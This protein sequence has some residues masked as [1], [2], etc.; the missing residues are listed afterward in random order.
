MN[1]FNSNVN[2]YSTL[3]TICYREMVYLSVIIAAVLVCNHVV[4]DPEILLLL[5]FGFQE[6]VESEEA[7]FLA[8]RIPLF[9]DL[10]RVEI[11]NCP[12][13]LQSCCC[14]VTSCDF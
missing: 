12:V 10:F 3:E 6:A 14:C 7:P 1:T 8:A 11:M 2:A 13:A 5:E 9:A 4:S